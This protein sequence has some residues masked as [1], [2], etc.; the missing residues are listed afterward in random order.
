M[1][2]DGLRSVSQSILQNALNDRPKVEPVA[3]L[4][5]FYEAWNLTTWLKAHGFHSGSQ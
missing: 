4:S 2:D 3:T 1:H 5:A